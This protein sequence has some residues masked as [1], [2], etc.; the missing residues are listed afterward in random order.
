MVGASLD[1]AIDELTNIRR[2]AGDPET[3]GS[4]GAAAV[5]ST[6]DD[7]ARKVEERIQIQEKFGGTVI[8]GKIPLI[9]K[10]RSFFMRAGGLG[11]GNGSDGLAAALAVCNRH[12]R[13]RSQ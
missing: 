10:N 4:V 13:H 12:R 1:D 3:G 2:V 7:I 8:A 6:A 11:A 5:E 9:G